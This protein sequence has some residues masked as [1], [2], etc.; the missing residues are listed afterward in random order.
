VG[1]ENVPTATVRDIEIYYEVHGSGERTLLI[2]GTGGDLARNPWRGEG[3]LE[4]QFQVLMYD[5]RGL[6]QSGKPDAP[7]TMS[8]YADDA[9]AL[10]DELGWPDCNVVGV[11]FGGM[12]AQHLAIRHPDRIRRLVLACSSAGGE[13][14]AS[15]DLLQLEGL[16][17]E[18]RLRRWLPILDSRNDT[19]LTPWTIAP[20]FQMMLA[21][22]TPGPPDTTKA[23]GALRQLQARAGHD[24][25][26]QLPFVKSETLV[27]GGIYDQQ[28][29]P[30]NQEMLAQRI[31]GAQLTFCD[32]GH[33]F[34]WQEPSAWEKIVAFLHGQPLGAAPS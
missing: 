34:L 20:G 33:I 10:L 29:S 9:A 30:K 26:E 15:Y 28:A 6:G 12:V 14:G 18:E 24:V 17:P 25:W 22:V 3:L 8:D 32:G 5:Q 16:D 7:Y 31:P 27:I 19:S 1:D 23:M 11:S 13:G 4:K 2:S 21:P